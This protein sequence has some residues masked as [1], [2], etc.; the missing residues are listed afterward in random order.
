MRIIIIG[1]RIHHNPGEHIITKSIRVIL[2]KNSHMNIMH[3]CIF[4][5]D[6]S[7]MSIIPFWWKEGGEERG[8][9]QFVNEAEGDVQR[10]LEAAHPAPAT[11][12]PPVLINANLL[13]ELSPPSLD[14]G[15]TT[16]FTRSTASSERILVTASSGRRR[17]G[18][19]CAV[20]P[21]PRCSPLKLSPR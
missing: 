11:A 2:S 7:R 15:S 9:P 5:I 1:K 6:S 10:A 13:G 18:A 21:P 8:W 17:P 16:S 12:S 14:A 19:R 20:A 3:F 4:Y